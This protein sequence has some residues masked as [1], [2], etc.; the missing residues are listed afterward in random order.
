MKWNGADLE[1]RLCAALD[2]ARK[3]IDYFAVSGHTDRERPALGFG[4]EK[5]VAETAML[6]YAAS[7]CSERPAV[8]RRIADLVRL[9]EPHARSERVLVDIAL[10]PAVAFKYAVPHVLLTRI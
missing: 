3:T 10:H 5:P 6:L 1:R 4:G 8:A 9:V 7:A 2:I